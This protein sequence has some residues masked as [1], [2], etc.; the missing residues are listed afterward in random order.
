MEIRKVASSATL[1]RLDWLVGKRSPPGTKFGSLL[2]V[3]ILFSIG[4]KDPRHAARIWD[5]SHTPADGTGRD[6]SHGTGHIVESS[7]APSE[8]ALTPTLVC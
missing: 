8:L 7:E 6:T 3:G 2:V 5:R 4:G 1:S